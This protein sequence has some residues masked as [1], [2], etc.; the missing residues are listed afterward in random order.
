ME[1][2]PDLTGTNVTERPKGVTADGNVVEVLKGSRKEL[3]DLEDDAELKYGN[4]DDAMLRVEVEISDE[5]DE[6]TV[7]Y[8][9]AYY[10][11]PSDRSDFGKYINMYGVP[12]PGQEVTVKFDSDGDAEVVV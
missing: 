2:N 5:V 7:Y 11:E 9:M 3:Y 1:S 8:D 6:F 4:L 10:E 12:E